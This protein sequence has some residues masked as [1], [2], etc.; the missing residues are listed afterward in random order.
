MPIENLYICKKYI[1]KIRLF[2]LYLFCFYFSSC[3][4]T[5]KLG[6]DEHLLVKNA[7]DI[8]DNQISKDNYL[9][10][11]RQ[12]P[13]KE[14]LGVPLHLYIYNLSGADTSKR[15]N[16]WLQGIGEMPVIYQ[17]YYKERTASQ[18]KL[19]LFN[20]GF[21]EAEVY[22]SVF[23]KKSKAQVLYKIRLGLPY[24]IRSVSYTI[25][26][27]IIKNLI[28]EDTLNYQFRRGQIFDLDK[29]DQDRIAIDKKLKNKG[30]YFFSPD[31]LRFEADTFQS[32]RVVDLVLQLYF[33]NEK[34]IIPYR[35]GD[36]FIKNPCST[37]FSD[38]VDIQGL[39]IV[40]PQDQII[41]TSVLKN[42]LSLFPDSLYNEEDRRRTVVNINSLKVFRMAELSYVENLEKR[43]R[44]DAIV[45][46][47][48]STMQSYRVDL[49]GTNSSGDLGVAGSFA[50]SHNN[51]FFGAESFNL[52][53]RSSIETLHNY[54]NNAFSNTVEFSADA[55]LIVPKFM[56][57]IIHLPKF[58][59]QYN[60]K[61]NIT[62]AYNYQ[63]R[64]DYTRFISTA[65]FGYFW[66]SSKQITHILNPVNFDLVR[67]PPRPELD[68]FI[69]QI[70]GTYL[71]NSFKD[72]L[73][74]G[75]DYS[76]IFSANSNRN[77]LI[78]TFVRYHIET[79]GNL[80]N[81][82]STWAGAQEIDNSFRVF[83]V[84]YS[85]YIIN[86][87][88]YRIYKSLNKTDN[89]VFRLFGGIGLAYNNNEVLPF[90]KKFYAGGPN[91]MRA[92]Q[93]RTLGP[94]SFVG[95]NITRY[96]N[97]LGDVKLESNIEYRFN[98]ISVLN[99][100]VFTDIGNVWSF[101]NTDQK[102]GVQFNLD[103]FTNELA[104]GSGVGLRFDF[105]FF[106]L[107]ADFGL[108]IVDPQR[109]A[110]N[111]VT[112]LQRKFNWNLVNP[113]ISIGYPF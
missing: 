18:L 42:S 12:K 110:N 60:P 102:K 98:I 28:L 78:K 8:D 84:Q 49:E 41:K 1:L 77:S 31:L 32:E 68:V 24:L 27:S 20:R 73:I 11:I 2:I 17:D 23:F 61:T 6:D 40:C 3:S 90:E 46:L 100:A 101:R 66:N 108:K 25:D 75:S 47:A 26:D 7:I 13:N 83:G 105:S 67:L 111:R 96:P 4:L 81:L 106:I 43:D 37:S 94:G 71:E 86:D 69:N 48:P 50:Y 85:Q 113:T 97:S 63:E 72:H 74:V 65:K 56:M 82:L 35:I 54:E 109:N 76:L 55:R 107:R 91:S 22:D 14:I 38:T 44:M 88:D 39:K 45:N 70:S 87:I 30:Y 19:Y 36:I 21:R 89:L 80:L 104:V 112:F 16:K 29:L 93:M 9:R 10:L 64:P 103:T 52:G 15:I 59:R 34:Q 62:M 95:E 51:L 99:G 53:F 33:T 92:W 57:P 79:A 58:V 5:K